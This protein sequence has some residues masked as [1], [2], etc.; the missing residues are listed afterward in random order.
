MAAPGEICGSPLRTKSKKECCQTLTRP[1][2]PSIFPTLARLTDRLR[3]EV[4]ASYIKTKS[5]NIAGT[6]YS[7]QNPMMQTIWTGRQVDW[8]KLKNY[9]NPDGTQFS[10]NHNFHDNPYWM[11]YKN[12]NTL[13]NDRII[14]N[15]SLSYR[16]TDWLDLRVR[17]GTDF[18]SGLREQILLIIQ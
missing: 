8:N 3:F 11:L 18:I 1:V 12:V 2:I 14:G 4:K 16:F 17:T 9:E 13:D 10:W 6:G 7:I 5:D 15:A